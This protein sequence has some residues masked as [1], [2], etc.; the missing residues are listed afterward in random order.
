MTS[1]GKS[2][3]ENNTLLGKSPQAPVLHRGHAQ[4]LP[5]PPCSLLGFGG[6]ADRSAALESVWLHEHTGPSPIRCPMSAERPALSRALLNP[7]GCH[8]L[9]L[10]AH[11][12]D[13]RA[14]AQGRR[15]CLPWG[16]WEAIRLSLQG[17]LLMGGLVP[18][19]IMLS[20]VPELHG[21]IDKS[22]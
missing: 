22:S 6:N 21:Y 13:G 19:V 2:K 17:T 1:E 15:T 5:P 14:E 7:D 9:G 16:S 3:T 10:C 12:M 18:Q 4:G 11:F 8:L 20:S